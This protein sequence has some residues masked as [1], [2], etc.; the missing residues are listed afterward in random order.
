MTG[1]FTAHADEP[2]EYYGRNGLD[3]LDGDTNN[4][5]GAYDLLLAGLTAKEA[6]ISMDTSNPIPT[7]DLADVMEAIRNDRPELYFVDYIGG[8]TYSYFNESATNY[9]YSVNP[10]YADT[11]ISA[12]AAAAFEAGITELMTDAHLK[13]G[14]TQVEKEKALHDALCRKVTYNLSATNAH[15]AYGA[16]VDGQAVCEGYARA[17]QL[18]LNRV[19]MSSHV[20]TGD[21][22]S[23]TTSEAHAWNLVK[24]GSDYCYTDVTWDDQTTADE[25]YD[26]VYY[27]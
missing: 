15:S 5:I 3:A 26:G 18:L 12:E 13:S 6:T 11:L 24:I 2:I 20:V 4:L 23:S 17:F 21:A 7:D 14:M 25:K 8:Y 22:I 1:A 9:V 16:I 27:G 19:G 10:T